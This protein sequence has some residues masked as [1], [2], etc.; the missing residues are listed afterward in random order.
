MQTQQRHHKTSLLVRGQ[1]EFFS[2]VNRNL[3]GQLDKLGVELRGQRKQLVAFREVIGDRLRRQ[4]CNLQARQETCHFLQG[5]IEGK[6]AGRHI[7]GDL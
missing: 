1:W 7:L 5:H 4:L 6:A 2:S 3:V